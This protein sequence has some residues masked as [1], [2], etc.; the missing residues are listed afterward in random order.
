MCECSNN[1]SLVGCRGNVVAG[2]A[3]GIK[4]ELG[5]ILLC[6][7]DNRKLHAS[8]KL[9][10]VVSEVLTITLSLLDGLFEEM[11]LLWY[12]AFEY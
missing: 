10:I 12:D 8:S 1:F 6:I 9:C 11:L 4:N 3:D 7:V 5:N 2:C